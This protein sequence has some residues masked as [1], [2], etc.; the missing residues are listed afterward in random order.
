MPSTCSMLSMGG[1]FRVFYTLPE[2]TSPHR[3]DAPHTPPPPF[4]ISFTLPLSLSL[5]LC[6][7]ER[8][9]QEQGVACRRHH[10][11]ASRCFFS[12]FLEKQ[13]VAFLYFLP[14]RL[15]ARTTFL[16]RVC[17]SLVGRK[18]YPRSQKSHARRDV[19]TLSLSLSL[20]SSAVHSRAT[21][22]LA[23]VNESACV[24]LL[25]RRGWRA[26]S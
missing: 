13:Y 18:A 12:C 20:G 4:P 21:K 16:S 1:A 9:R 15:T 6:A 7:Q 23:S 2:T 14:P 25:R 3:C 8:H 22:E 19:I 24:W 11:G 5:T 17:V 10:A 26:H